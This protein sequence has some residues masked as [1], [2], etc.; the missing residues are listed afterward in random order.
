VRWSLVFLHRRSLE[1]P[2]RSGEGEGGLPRPHG[3]Q[4]TPAHAARYTVARLPGSPQTRCRWRLEQPRP[5]GLLGCLLTTSGLFTGAARSHWGGARKE[6]GG[7]PRHQG[8]PGCYP[9]PTARRRLHKALNQPTSAMSC[10][11]STKHVHGSC[12][13]V[14]GPT[15]PSL[16][17]RAPAAADRSV[18]DEAATHRRPHALPPAATDEEEHGV[19]GERLRPPG[20]PGR[21]PHPAAHPPRHQPC[22]A[23]L[24]RCQSRQHTRLLPPPHQ[25]ICSIHVI[26]SLQ[27]LFSFPL[28][29]M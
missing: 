9:N 28:Q 14:P 15:V 23:Q 5:Q 26:V 27:P 1:P 21:H 13:S 4:A 2:K 20:L 18:L 17:M 6:G 22:H 3:L 16:T 19:R 25:V 29:H 8:L 11:A 12:S 10:A 24:P 7:L